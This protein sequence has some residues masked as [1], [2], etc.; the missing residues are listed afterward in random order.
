MA[1]KWRLFSEVKK[2]SFLGK[3]EAVI[4]LRFLGEFRKKREILRISL[5]TGH[6]TDMKIYGFIQKSNIDTTILLFHPI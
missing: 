3:F 1:E 5:K 6:K 4:L 2:W